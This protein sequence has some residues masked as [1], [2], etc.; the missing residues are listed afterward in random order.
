[1]FK[2]GDKVKCVI[3]D[4]ETA[5]CKNLPSLALLSLNEVYEV[6]EYIGIQDCKATMFKQAARWHENGGRMEVKAMPGL[7]F[8]GKRFAP[9]EN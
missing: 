9:A 3:L 7:L 6:S 5:D 8:F 2:T 4:D 1:M